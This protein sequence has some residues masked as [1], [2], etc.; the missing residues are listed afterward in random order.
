MFALQQR[1][2]ANLVNLDIVIDMLF[3]YATYLVGFH[4]L[5]FARSLTIYLQR[6]RERERE[7][8]EEEGDIERERER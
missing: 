4:I 6:E 7:R 2:T 5:W 8:A 3:T 1:I